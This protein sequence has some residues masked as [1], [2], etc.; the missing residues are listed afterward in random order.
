M[1]ARLEEQLI[2]DVVI[3][4]LHMDDQALDDLLELIY[5]SSVQT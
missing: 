5:N 1:Q 3:W 2:S 4:P